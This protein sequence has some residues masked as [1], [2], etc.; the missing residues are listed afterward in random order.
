[1]CNRLRKGRT[2]VDSVSR[3]I[4]P[5]SKDSRCVHNFSIKHDTA[6]Y[7]SIAN[8]NSPSKAPNI[9]SHPPRMQNHKS[10]FPS[11]FFIHFLSFPAHLKARF[12]PSESPHTQPVLPDHSYS[13]SSAFVIARERNG[14]RLPATCTR[15]FCP[16]DSV[17]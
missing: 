5:E 9:I 8:S 15:K 11:S 16:P 10:N 17:D 6:V 2:A 7:P 12:A 4:M 14:E 13:I 1:V 3:G